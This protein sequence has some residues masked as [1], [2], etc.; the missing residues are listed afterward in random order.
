MRL[1]M[2]LLRVT[3]VGQVINLISNDVFRFDVAFKYV[4]YLWIGPLGTISIAYFLWLE[5][6]WSAFFGV[7]ILFIFIPLQGG[8]H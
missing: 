4:H 7:S 5:I 3:S 2:H 8:P 6:G 1:S